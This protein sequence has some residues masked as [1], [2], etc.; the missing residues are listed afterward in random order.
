MLGKH[1][2]VGRDFFLTQMHILAVIQAS[3][4]WIFYQKLGEKAEITDCL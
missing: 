4:E 3:P 2:S 1:E